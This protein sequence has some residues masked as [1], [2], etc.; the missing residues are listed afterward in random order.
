M[1]PSSS[2]N[3]VA[4]GKR[5]DGRTRYW[6]LLH[7]ADATE[8]YGKPAKQCRYAHVLPAAANEVLTV[9]TRNF[10]GGVA[11]WGA[12]PPVYDTT[13]LPVEMGVHVHARESVGGM[14]KIDTTYREVSLVGFS[15]DLLSE[16]VTISELDAIYHM[17]ST[18]FGFK[19][20]YIKCTLCGYPHLDK[21]WF[22]V[23]VHQRH[24]CSG[25]GRNFRDSERAI[26]NPLAWVRQRF[27]SPHRTHMASKKIK[28]S[29]ADFPGGIQIWGSNPAIV[30]TSPL[31][32]E[33]GI[34]VHAFGA[35]PLD[36]TFSE[37]VIDGI[38]L[39]PTMVRVLMV[40]KALPHI[41][42]RITKVECPNC[43]KSHFDAGEH[44][45]TPHDSHT[46][47]NCKSDFQSSGR[48][49]KV[50][51]NPI[52]DVFKRLALNAPRPERQHEIGLL[53]ETI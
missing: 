24:L 13:E 20:K 51:G 22:S 23:H 12:V 9:D 33:E 5:R 2:C 38:T 15:N 28:L 25:C 48:L 42:G 32:E 36:D 39:D 49:R 37:V 1:V 53:S 52:V 10:V 3:I 8:K 7:K 11:L 26:G 14:K 50:I 19:T 27:D 17:V 34:H 46:C 16:A 31:D 35:D 40:Q 4:V 43:H 44:A 6:C 21:D 45:F 29:Q 47:S 30:W 18:V 41:A